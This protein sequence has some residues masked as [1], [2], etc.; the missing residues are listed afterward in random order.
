MKIVF[1]NR[2]ERWNGGGEPERCQVYI[3]EDQGCWT[4][5]CSPEPV[6]PDEEAGGDVWYE[7]L[8]WEELLATFRHGVARIMREGF[9]PVID[10]MLEDLP[11]WERRPSL[12]TLLRC[13]AESLP[14]PEAL[15]ELKAWRKAKA[16]EERKSAYFIA[17]NREL[18]MLAV[19]VPHTPEE[20]MQIPGFG[21]WKAQKYGEELLQILRK[22]G[23]EHRFPLDWVAER[24]DPAML[25]DWL[26]AQREQKYAKL[27]EAI[28]A[29]HRLLALI[30][31]GK[32]L[33]EME[34]QLQCS[35]R[36]LAERVEKLDMEGYDVLP[37]VERE[38]SSLPEEELKRVE[39]A[40]AEL[41]D[42]YLKPLYDRVYGSAEAS[43][44]PVIQYS[45]LRL[46]RIRFR[47]RQAGRAADAS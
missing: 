9:R 26:I 34:S 27:R 19:Y 31:E 20:L 2:L 47:R 22:M 25:A 41:G 33:R 36:E 24:V 45:R 14:E 12:Q 35:P 11:F 7:G 15:G 6:N 8:S 38:L 17:T 10:G 3:A 43:E 13:Y 32:T 39:E 21:K 1:V 5:G 18:H 30:R 40:F 44:D 23:R 29:K 42:R 16:V 37:L 28:A 46:A 4:T